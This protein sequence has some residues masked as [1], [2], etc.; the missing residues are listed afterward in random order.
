[1]SEKYMYRASNVKARKLVLAMSPKMWILR[2]KASDI[3]HASTNTD[4]TQN[5]MEYMWKTLTTLDLQFVSE[6][7]L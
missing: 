2:C 7:L 3:F 6:G 5:Q 4:N 1:M